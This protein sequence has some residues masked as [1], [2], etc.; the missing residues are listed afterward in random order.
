MSDD[1]QLLAEA[2]QWA[3]K[4]KRPFDADLVQKVV[5]LRRNY[6]AHEPG[7]WPVG[8]A[9][10][11][12]LVRWPAH[13]PL[14]VPDPEELTGTL[15]TFWRFLRGTGRM[16]GTSA[17]PADLVKEL[18]R[19]LPRMAE[20][21]ADRA[22]WGQGRVFQDFGRTIG[23][24]LEGA[25]SQEELEAAM[26]QIQTQW[27]ALPMDERIAL[28]P[29]P[30]PKSVEGV[31]L[32]GL[33]Q[34]GEV[35]PWDDEDDL[36]PVVDLAARRTGGPA[37]PEDAAAALIEELMRRGADP[38]AVLQALT[39]GRGFGLEQPEPVLKPARDE[40]VVYRIRV[41][42]VDTEP[43]VWRCLDLPSDLHLD[44][45][46]L[47]LQAAMGW[48]DVHLHAFWLEADGRQAVFETDGDEAA[49][50]GIH[51][52]DVRLDQVLSEPGDCINYDYDFGDGWEHVVTL[53]KV[54]TEGEPGV[55]GGARACPPENCGGLPGYE[56]LVRNVAEGELPEAFDSQDDLD[57]W[58]PPDWDPEDF[59]VDDA[60]TDV[61]A[62]LA[63]GWAGI[64]DLD[65]LDETLASM[66]T[67][68]RGTAVGN[69]LADIAVLAL[70]ADPQDD[71]FRDLDAEI[72]AWMRP[73]Q[74][75]LDVVGDG[76]DLTG[77]GYL[78]PAAVEQ[79]FTRLDM[80]SQ[81]IG[82]GNREDLTPPVADLRRLARL[83][84]LVR[85]VKGRLVPTKAGRDLR[86]DPR[87]LWTWIAG[88]LPAGG[89]G[90][91]EPPMMLLLAVAGGE[92]PSEFG[93]DTGD[94]LVSIGWNGGSFTAKE[95]NAA[96]SA[97]WEIL[98]LIGGI[99]RQGQITDLGQ[100][101]AETAI[102]TRG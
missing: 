41:G 20:T 2:T 40:P 66:L 81:W 102:R 69:L 92:I 67:R 21:A 83:L 89:D 49:S 101:L 19:A 46:H 15:D 3:A 29:D 25:S 31:A 44:R 75:L 45:L 80:G 54:L 34:G 84:G 27:N 70:D 30:S 97:T 64:P 94:V 78:R 48:M 26:T 16:S 39:G 11:L 61:K 65:T 73:L 4:K 62:V 76:V 6:D 12:V 82:K 93:E 14:E 7:S 86:D 96:M 60:D 24:D 59:D 100:T 74:V 95:A 55:V 23:V 10:S 72:A 38:Q 18:R 90:R 53:E 22:N 87:G 77:A 36:A 47:V 68:A 56:Q 98:S 33:L 71:P 1:E 35:P 50:C 28:M 52:G 79:I 99:D 37:V 91:L 43:P 63:G 57:A 8:S 85:V 88:R 5:D 42:L 58:L 13:G 51:E 32:T 9:E 17:A